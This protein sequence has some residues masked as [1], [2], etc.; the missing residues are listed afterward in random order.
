MNKVGTRAG[1]A[2]DLDRPSLRAAAHRAGALPAGRRAPGRGRLERRQRARARVVVQP[3]G[4]PR[5]RDRDPRRASAGARASRRGRGARGAVAEGER[6]CTRASTTTT[7]RTSRDIAVFVL[8]PR[9][10]TRRATAAATRRADYHRWRAVGWRDAHA[11]TPPTPTGA[12]AMTPS[13]STEQ[14]I[15]A[16]TSSRCLRTTWPPPPSTARRSACALGLHARAALRRVRDGQPHAEH[17]RRREDGARAPPAA[18]RRSRCTWTTWA[19]AQD[20]RRARR[21]SS[22]ATPLDTGVCH[23]AFFADPEGN[24]FMLHHRYAPRVSEA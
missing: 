21:G 7:R 10:P 1:A 11:A 22:A 19:S 16:S 14:L 17:H 15:A 8:E 18:D 2:A 20:A 12:D 9:W 4:Q 5:R 23:M 6:A 3:E 24:R 13:T